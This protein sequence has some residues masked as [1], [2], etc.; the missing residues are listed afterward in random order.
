MYP[1]AYIILK[2]AVSKRNKFITMSRCIQYCRRYCRRQSEIDEFQV[3]SN[4]TH[5]LLL[6]L[7]FYLKLLIVTIELI[8]F[9]Y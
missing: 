4:I 1:T 9:E 2:I 6:E 5:F 8:I 7:S 3:I